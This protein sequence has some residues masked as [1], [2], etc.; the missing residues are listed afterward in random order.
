MKYPLVTIGVINYNYSKYVVNALDSI[1][2][3]TYPNI[4]IIIIDDFSTDDSVGIID[5]WIFR[6]SKNT[7]IH[8]IKN[9]S[10]QGLAKNSNTILNFAN[11]KYFQILDADDIILPEKTFNQVEII[12]K[13]QN[14]AFAFSDVSVINENGEIIKENYFV[15]IGYFDKVIPS[16]K[17]FENL[18]QFNFVPLP[19]V[20]INTNYAKIVGGFNLK[21]QVQDYYMWLKLTES[22]SAVYYPQIVGYY[23]IHSTSMS[24][25]SQTKFRSYDDVLNIKFRYIKNVNKRARIFIEDEIRYMSPVLYRF[26]FHTAKKWLWKSFK[27]K[28]SFKT[29]IYIFCLH[30]GIPYIYLHKLKK[31]IIG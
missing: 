30:I 18:L 21:F 7:N 4:E 8:Y 9:E 20:L 26:G 31:I 17:I 25:N 24:N 10:N 3:Q 14:C 5:E 16:G 27:I 2:S 22:Y 11:G 12:E 19:S 13:N 23:R 29:L 6:N 28:P 1:L 15:Q